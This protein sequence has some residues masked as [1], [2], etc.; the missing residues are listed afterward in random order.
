MTSERSALIVAVE[1]YQDTKLRKLRT[2][3]RDA[4]QLER[5]LGNPAIGDFRVE[6]CANEPEHVMRRKIAKFFAN[7]RRDDLLL[8]HIACHGLKDDFGHLYFAASDT[9]VEQLDS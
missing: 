7:R 1:E 2:P 5:V 4:E 9:E 3:S 6:L 8:L